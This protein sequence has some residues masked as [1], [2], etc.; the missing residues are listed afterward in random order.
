[1]NM[2]GRNS[3][4]DEVI[5]DLSVVS[6][7]ELVVEVDHRG[8]FLQSKEEKA[9]ETHLRRPWRVKGA[10]CRK[11]DTTSRSAVSS[12]MS[13]LKSS[14]PALGQATHRP[15]VCVEL[16][17]PVQVSRGRCMVAISRA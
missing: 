15:K 8:L 5:L 7:G 4:D 13:S 9:K 10:S 11:R 14:Q 6:S 1:M 17:E 3:G 12:V 2:T 16:L